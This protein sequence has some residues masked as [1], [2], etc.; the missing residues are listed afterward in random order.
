M[1]EARQRG[2]KTGGVATARGAGTVIWLRLSPQFLDVNT[3]Y[4]GGAGV[5]KC[6]WDHR[7][8]C[9]AGRRQKRHLNENLRSRRGVSLRPKDVDRSPPDNLDRRKKAQL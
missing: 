4:I 2:K 1:S 5:D 9:G 8:D 6:D 3:Q 7:G